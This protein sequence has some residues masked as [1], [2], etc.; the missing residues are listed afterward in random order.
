MKKASP[1]SVILVG[2]P[3]WAHDYIIVAED[4]LKFD[5]IMYTC[6]HFYQNENDGSQRA[7][8]DYALSKGAPKFVAEWG[9]TNSS[10]NGSLYPSG[11][12]EW[13]S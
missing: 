8:I 3:H 7:N 6:R 4:P 10:A 9:S 5:N 12:Y 13:I 2:N 1:K 11:T